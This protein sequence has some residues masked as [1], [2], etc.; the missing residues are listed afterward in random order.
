[1][2]LRK[3]VYYVATTLDGFTAGPEG[4]DPSGAGYFPLTPDGMQYIVENY[5][6]TMPGPAREALGIDHP[7]R[8]F[9]VNA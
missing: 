5:P 4:G 9:L 3:L 8:T 2:T 7:G 1:M 6:E